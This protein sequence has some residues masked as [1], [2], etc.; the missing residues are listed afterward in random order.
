MHIEFAP[1][2]F[3]RGNRAA[4]RAVACGRIADLAEVGPVG[5]RQSQILV[6]HRH[7]AN[8]EVARD[9]ACDLEKP[10]RVSR[11]FLTDRVS[12]DRVI[13]F[14]VIGTFEVFY[15][16]S[17][18]GPDI[19]FRQFRH[20][21][22]PAAHDVVAADI[23][24]DDVA[25]EDVSKRGIL[26]AGHEDRQVF[27]RRGDEPRVLRVNMKISLF[28]FVLHQSVH[29][30]VGEQPLVVAVGFPPQFENLSLDRAEGVVLGNARIG[31]PVQPP[32]LQFLF[33]FFLEECLS[34]FY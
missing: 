7:D 25:D 2:D 11:L 21:F 16:F 32:A 8:R 10:D 13:A 23:A 4:V 5:T 31:D 14:V 28:E 19:I 29:E 20:V 33:L 12:V 3:F 17:Q 15:G 1:R 34:I 9:A 26:P 30:L 22:R 6:N 27:F 24:V 18:R